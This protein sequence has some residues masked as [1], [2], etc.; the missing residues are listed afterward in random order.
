M[1]DDQ[2]IQESID[3]INSFNQLDDSLRDKL[4]NGVKCLV[5]LQ[6][7]A[8]SKDKPIKNQQE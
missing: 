1:I 3:A 2:Q 7:L 8:N 5:F 4:L 6:D